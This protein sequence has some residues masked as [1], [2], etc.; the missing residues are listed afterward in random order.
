MNDELA[1]LLTELHQHGVEHDAAQPNRLDRLRNLDPDAAEL[2]AVL[3]RAANARTIREIGTSTGYSTLWLADA[4]RDIAG[5]SRPWT[6]TP[7]GAPRSP[8]I[9]SVPALLGGSTCR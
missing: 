2:M 3:V 8:S 1:Q 5:R 9:S 6:S 4:A 7:A